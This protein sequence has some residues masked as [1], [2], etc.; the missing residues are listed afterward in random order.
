MHVHAIFF[1]RAYLRPSSVGPMAVLAV[2]PPSVG[3]MSTS[4]VTVTETLFLVPNPLLSFNP[5]EKRFYEN[6]TST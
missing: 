2:E 5:E 3:M 6:T 1:K 4:A